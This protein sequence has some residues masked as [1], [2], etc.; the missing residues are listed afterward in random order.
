MNKKKA[1]F[2]GIAGKTMAPLAKAFLDLD[3]EV[4]GSD[5]KEIYPPMSTYLLENKIPYVEGYRT[6]N[7][8]TDA[9][10]VV[11]GR[12]AILVDSQ[13]P[14]YLQ[15]KKLG[16]NIKSYPEVLQEY[17]VKRN[18]IVIAGTYG[19]TTITALVALILKN[20]GLD[21]SYMIGGIPLDMEDGVKIT[22]SDFSVVEGD[23]PPAL[24]ETDPP[25]FMFYKPK[26][27]LLTATYWDH[28]EIF[29]TENAYINA[30]VNL[31]RLLP[32]EGLLVY[33]L[34]KVSNLVV[35]EAGCR[36]ISY[37]LENPQA[38]YF[39][40]TLKTSLIG[41][42][43]LENI[44][45]AFALCSEL[46][47]PKEIIIKSVGQFKGVKTRLEF[48][49]KFGGRFLYW[50]LAQH[51]QKVRGTVSALRQHYPKEKIIAVYH[52][53]AS[54]LKYRQILPALENV[55]DQV[56]QV[57]VTKASFLKGI[58][59]EE[60][61][62]GLDLAKAISKTQKN[63]FYQPVKEKIIDYLQKKTKEDE[64]IVFLSSGGLEFV[65]L[66]DEVKEKLNER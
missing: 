38:C 40:I 18:S 43:N 23:E 13:N 20:A 36:K 19:K 15:A 62:S 56:D 30:F 9:D 8:P 32:K 45:G 39:K 25:K 57:I 60:R 37:S 29:K 16:L 47:I 6:E 63:V 61:V 52:P 28:P 50:D 26:Y 54:V 42:S 14:E 17:L 64:V 10:L 58:S 35:K 2:I 44:C 51:P 34:D 41:K 48:L 3:W 22:N 5:H 59:R 7:V 53:A 65:S 24:F 33:N 1:Y 4:S 55:F 49:G 46:G 12:S 11:V 66:I 27:L 21:P 31:V